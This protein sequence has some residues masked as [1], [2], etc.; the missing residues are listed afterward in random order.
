MAASEPHPRTQP[1]PSGVEDFL[2]R[3]A[4]LQRLDEEIGRAERH[5]TALSC[6]LVAMEDFGESEAEHGGELQEQLLVYVAGALRREL[7]RFDRIGRPSER[8]LLIVLPGADARRGETVARRVLD[9]LRTIKVEAAGV[10][11]VPNVS[12]GLSS[13]R[14]PADAEELLRRTSDA[15][16]PGGPQALAPNVDG[17]SPS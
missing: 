1:L 14:E 8:E 16:R 7:R 15:A 5:S 2:S 12:V 10:R 9:R 3:P 17:P 4:L 13:W 11:R 6:L